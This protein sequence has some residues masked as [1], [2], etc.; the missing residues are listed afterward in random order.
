[1]LKVANYTQD[2]VVFNKVHLTATQLHA[3]ALFQ[4]MSQKC[5]VKFSDCSGR[6]I[7]SQRPYHW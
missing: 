6:Q 4:A 3:D 1:M 5:G 2:I 7:G